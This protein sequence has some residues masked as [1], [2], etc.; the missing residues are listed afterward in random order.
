MPSTIAAAGAALV[1][2][3]AASP[4]FAAGPDA[5]LQP[6]V[7]ISFGA[8]TV[9][10]SK[11]VV[12][13]LDV[14]EVDEQPAELGNRTMEETYVLR[15]G[16]KCHKPAGTERETWTRGW[17]MYE[18]VRAVVKA[19]RTLNDTVRTALVA[20]KE[21]GMVQGAEGGGF[22]IFILVDVDVDARIS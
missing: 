20:R 10:E 13:L 2:L 5:L 17:E 14:R 8:P 1:D 4:A 15:L 22:V 3:L 18:A 7:Q 16:V 9:L 11:E 6:A 21:G 19:N 12:A